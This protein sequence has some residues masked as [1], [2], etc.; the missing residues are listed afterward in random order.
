[1]NI[2]ALMKQAQKMQK[3]MAIRE[4]ELQEKKY[5]ASVNNNTIKVVANGEM[6]IE[7]INIDEE[8]LTKENKEIVEDLIIM[9]INDVVAKITKDKDETLQELTGGVKVPGMF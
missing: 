5:E 9:A 3:E 8:L 1:M 6:K 7:S 2:N 4:K